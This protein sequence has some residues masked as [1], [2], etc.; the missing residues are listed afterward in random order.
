MVLK[1]DVVQFLLKKLNYEQLETQQCFM[2]RLIFMT[3]CSAVQT[4]RL[5]KKK[6]TNCVLQYC[7]LSYFRYA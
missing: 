7:S 3:D 2:L 5:Y 1:T 4:T 6:I